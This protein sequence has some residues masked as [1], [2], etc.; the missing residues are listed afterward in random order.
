M[1][2]LDKS[3]LL[4]HAMESCALCAG[5]SRKGDAA[6]IWVKFLVAQQNPNAKGDPKRFWSNF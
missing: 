1:F 3:I 6:Q 4:V 5:L 2:N